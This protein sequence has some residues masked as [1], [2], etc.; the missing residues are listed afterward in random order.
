[1]SADKIGQRI[2]R[3]NAA[4]PVLATITHTTIKLI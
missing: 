3:A 1:M 4:M 2:P